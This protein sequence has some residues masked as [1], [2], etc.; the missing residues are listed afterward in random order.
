MRIAGDDPA[1]RRLGAERVEIFRL[2]VSIETTWRPSNRPRVLP[3]RTKLA[4]S[5]AKVTLKIASGLAASSARTVAPASMR[6]SARN[7]SATSHVG[8]RLQEQFLEPFHRRLAVFVVRRDDRP[9]PGRGLRRFLD[10]DLHVGRGP[11]AEGVAVALR[12]D[13]RVGQRLGGDAWKPLF[14]LAWWR[15]QPDIGE[16]AAG[17]GDRPSRRSR[18]RRRGAPRPPAAGIVAEDGLELAA[19]HAPPAALICSCT[20]VPMPAD[21]VSRKARLGGIGVDL[22]DADRPRATGAHG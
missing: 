6:P 7:C 14:W 9:F 10:G 12:P 3:A 16:E 17:N 1:F 21:R 2:A 13:E 5:T 20:P 22:A 15:R 11:Q 19:E 8:A 18:D 4:R